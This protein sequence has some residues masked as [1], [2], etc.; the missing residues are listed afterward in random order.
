MSGFRGSLLSVD[1]YL[2]KQINV[3]IPTLTVQGH[4]A[5]NES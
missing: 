2:S 1:K 4:L 3:I 5:Q